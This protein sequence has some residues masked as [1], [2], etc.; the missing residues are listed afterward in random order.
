VIEGGAKGVVGGTSGVVGG[1][2][3]AVYTVGGVV[4][5]VR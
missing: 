5:V 4:T 3:V 1:E 2:M